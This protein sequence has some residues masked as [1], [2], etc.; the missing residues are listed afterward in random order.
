MVAVSRIESAAALQILGQFVQRARRALLAPQRFR[1]GQ[2]PVGQDFRVRC[3]SGLLLLLFALGKPS[4]GEDQLLEPGHREAKPRGDLPR[5]PPPHVQRSRFLPRWVVR[6][7]LR[8]RTPLLFGCHN[9]LRIRS[10]A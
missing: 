9:M 3:V 5:L 1:E 7:K 8:P 4:L 2:F 6:F 10:D